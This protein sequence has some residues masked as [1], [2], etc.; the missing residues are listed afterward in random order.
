MAALRNMHEFED[1]SGKRFGSKVGCLL[2]HAL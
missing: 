1:E 2:L